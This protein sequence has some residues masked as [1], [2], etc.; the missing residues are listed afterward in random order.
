MDAD[1][2]ITIAFCL[3]V[4]LF[5]FAAGMFALREMRKARAEAQKA[6]SATGARRRT[7][8]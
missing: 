4:L 6:T 3:E 2:M 8:C 7:S 1:V 5:A